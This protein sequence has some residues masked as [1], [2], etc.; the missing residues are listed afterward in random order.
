MECSQSTVQNGNSFV[1]RLK[2]NDII[3]FCGFV[4]KQDKV[5]AEVWKRSAAVDEE[6]KYKT[7]VYT[8]HANNV[9]R[10]NTL[11]IDIKYFQK[12]VMYNAQS[13]KI[14]IIIA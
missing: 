10:K 12:L 9:M 14:P 1:P 6:L 5:A 3:E 2:V 4:C 13:P 11:Y 8:K 7:Y